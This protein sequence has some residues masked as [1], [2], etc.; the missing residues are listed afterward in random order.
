MMSSPLYLAAGTSDG[1][2]E[3]GAYTNTGS[4]QPAT[5]RVCVTA[6]DTMS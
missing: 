5:S 1:E 4:T 3:G 6:I 2:T